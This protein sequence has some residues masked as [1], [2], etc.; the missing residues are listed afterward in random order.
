MKIIKSEHLD[1]LREMK[2]ILFGNVYEELNLYKRKI[3]ILEFP[4]SKKDKDYC[5]K[6]LHR[7]SDIEQYELS[8][9]EGQLCFS[10]QKEILTKLP[11]MID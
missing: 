9:K 11:K 7:V 10:L 4:L 1:R 2:H 3:S 8:P 6:V 5:E